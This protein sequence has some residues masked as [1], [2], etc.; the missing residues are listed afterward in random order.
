MSRLTVLKCKAALKPGMYGDGGTLYL[1]VAPSGSRSW[2]QRLVIGGK[3][4]DIGLGGFPLVSLVEAR[5][6]AF[7]NRRLARRGGDP[8]A[9]K[10][11]TGVPSF[12]EAVEKT[13]E[14]TRPRWP[15]GRTY[16][17]H[18]AA[19]TGKACVPCFR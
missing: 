3:R 6:M 8:L 16:R 14:A 4:K 2:I 1:D 18:L 11:E 7:D 19:D 15:Q 12:K 13:I 5:E 17:K 10:R 9:G